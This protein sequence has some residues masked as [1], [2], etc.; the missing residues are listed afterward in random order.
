MEILNLILNLAI[1]V[2]LIILIN[3]I[4][5]IKSALKL[6]EYGVKSIKSENDSNKQLGKDASSLTTSLI[7]I[8]VSLNTTLRDL[9]LVI[10][11]KANEEIKK[12]EVDGI[13]E[14]GEKVVKT[15][16]EDKVMEES[17]ENSLSSKESGKDITIDAIKLE[18]SKRLWDAIPTV[19][20]KRLTRKHIGNGKKFS[21]LTGEEILTIYDREL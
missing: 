17:N 6:V 7:E 3:N 14:E 12:E 15:I 9:M 21:E 10:E 8:S 13:V 5:G 2:A 20:K 18:T 16:K 19:T 4:G 1:L 11:H